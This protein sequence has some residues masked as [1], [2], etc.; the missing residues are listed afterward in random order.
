MN[1]DKFIKLV[2]LADWVPERI[3]K[4]SRILFSRHLNI[5]N[6]LC[7]LHSFCY[8][9][10]SFNKL[11]K[12]DPNSLWVI[13]ETARLRESWFQIEEPEEALLNCLEK[14]IINGYD[15]LKEYSIY[16]AE[17]GDYLQA[18]YNYKQNSVL[19]LELYKNHFLR[20]EDNMQNVNLE[21]SLKFFKED[22]FFAC[23]PSYFLPHFACLALQEGH[24]SRNIKQKFSSE[25]KFDISVV[26]PMYLKTIS[27]KLKIAEVNYR[28][29]LKNKFKDGLIRYGFHF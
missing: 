9:L 21:Y 24:L 22:K 27:K 13:N 12:K 1:Q 23:I 7:T 6:A 20:F 10:R 5:N 29:L 18:S 25:V 14:A 19:E 8:S 4:L 11:L 16:L 26:N 28:F 2:A 3:L 15:R 17:K